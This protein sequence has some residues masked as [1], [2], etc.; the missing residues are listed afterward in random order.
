VVRAASFVGAIASLA[1]AMAV[2]A[3]T[4]DPAPYRLLPPAKALSGRSRAEIGL[5]ERLNRADQRHLW[6]LETVVVPEDWRDGD[7][8]HS[9]FPLVWSWAIR[10]P[11][12]LAVS[13]SGQAFGA[14][15]HGVLVRWG[16]I[17]SGRRGAETPSGLHWLNFRSKGRRSTV[18]EDWFMPWYFNF[19]SRGG[20]AFH[21]F[22]MPGLPAS[23]SCVRML[24]RDARW[25][26]GWGEEWKIDSSGHVIFQKGTP[27]LLLDDYDF[28][29]P[30]P[31]RSPEWLAEGVALPVVVD[32]EWD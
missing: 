25:L 23:H 28:G 32:G 12:A 29:A 31:W 21:E 19:R 13:L 1:I 15:E 17:S 14:Y 24:H 27:V 16:P 6:R 11:K 20:V 7:A 8:A 22:A 10:Y 18:D 30:P 3:S 2:P 5:L 26:Y 9:P 4:P